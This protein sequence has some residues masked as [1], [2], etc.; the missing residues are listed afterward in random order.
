MKKNLMKM[1]SRAFSPMRR[2]KRGEKGFTLIEVLIVVAILGVLAAVAIP[3]IS[4]FFDSGN[5]ESA[6]TE[7]ANVQLAVDN[8]MLANGIAV[9]P[10]PVAGYTEDMANFPDNTSVAV[11]GK[12]LDENG[13]AYVFPGDKAG[14]V[15]YGNDELGGGTTDTLVN[16]MRNSTTTYTYAVAAD[17]TVTQGP[18]A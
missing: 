18:K 17:G 14:Y 11:D 15:L 9:L 16:Y 8:M 5:T 2:V 13:D 10:N 3:N 1:V 6:A 7:L 12:V 4:K